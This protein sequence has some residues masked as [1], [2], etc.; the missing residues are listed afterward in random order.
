VDGSK[1]NYASVRN[2]KF[3]I[4]TEIFTE[5]RKLFFEDKKC[6]AIEWAFFK[7]LRQIKLMKKNTTLAYDMAKPLDDLSLCII[8]IFHLQQIYCVKNELGN[9]TNGSVSFEL[10][11]ILERQEEKHLIEIVNLEINWSI[12]PAVSCGCLQL[13]VDWEL[14]FRF[15]WA[16]TR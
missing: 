7:N 10:N 9:S 4:G 6:A 8:S 14:K 2:G 15:R 5:R 11:W 13:E 16:H 1:I 3:M 12:F